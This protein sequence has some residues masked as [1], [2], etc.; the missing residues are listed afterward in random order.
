MYLKISAILALASSV[1]QIRFR[2]LRENTFVLL[3]II[4]SEAFLG[5]HFQVLGSLI[6]TMIT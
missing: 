5:N 1:N 6:E 2:E 4:K 3:V